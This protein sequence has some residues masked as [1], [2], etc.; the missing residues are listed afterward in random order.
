MKYLVQGIKHNRVTNEITY[1]SYYED[2]N[3]KRYEIEDEDEEV[4]EEWRQK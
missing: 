1:F 4:K 2:E 3:G